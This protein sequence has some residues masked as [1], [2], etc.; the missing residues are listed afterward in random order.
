MDR[1]KLLGA[2][3]LGG[4]IMLITTATHQRATRPAPTRTRFSESEGWLG[5]AAQGRDLHTG[6]P[7]ARWLRR[8]ADLSPEQPSPKEPTDTGRH[9]TQR[10][11][12]D[13][14]E[15]DRHTSDPRE[16]DRRAP[17]PRETDQPVG[18]RT[19]R[20]ARAGGDRRER[21]RGDRAD[22]QRPQTWWSMT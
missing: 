19:D 16:T 22:R 20:P 21:K 5:Q 10:R 12:P 17:D 4:A 2:A 11:E 8:M 1:G 7:D 18:R 13:P 14:R 3:I 15:T 6:R 9:T